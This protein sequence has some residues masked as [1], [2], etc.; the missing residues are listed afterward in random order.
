VSFFWGFVLVAVVLGVLALV[1]RHKQKA[2]RA[3]AA[4]QRAS[5]FRG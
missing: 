1:G 3:K 4:E 2:A 5:A